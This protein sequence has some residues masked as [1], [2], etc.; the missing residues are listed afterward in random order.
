METIVN[1]RNL[2]GVAKFWE[3]YRACAEENRVRPDRSPFYVKWAKDFAGFLPEKPLETRSREHIQAFLADLG[4]RRGIAN[5]QVRQAEH[6]LRILYEIFL[7]RYARG[8]HSHGMS[9]GKQPARGPIAQTP[10]CRD[11]VIPGEVERQFPDLLDAVRT[12]VRTRHYSY[13]TETSYLDWVKRFIAFRNYADPREIDA[14]AAV[15]TYLEY[16]AVEREVAASTQNQALNALVF[17][18]GQVLQQPLGEMDQFVRARRPRRLPEVLTR[19]EIQMLLSKMTGITGLMAGLM[20][21]S[22]LRLMECVRLRV[23]DIDFAQHQILVRD[24]KGQKDRVTMLPERFATPLR[25]HLARV[26]AIYEQDSSQ[27]RADVYIWP[28]LERKYPSA[29]KE[30]IWQYVFPAKS[31]SVDPRSG[32]VRRHHINEN[33]LQKAVKEAAAQAAINKKVSCHTLRHYAE[34]GING[35][36]L[37]PIFLKPAMTFAQCRNSWGMPMWSP[38]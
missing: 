12:G 28:A 3:A 37:P 1:V 30:W 24:G 7:P 34:L 14:P 16:L 19:D 38:L 8:S 6:A 4:N 32:R 20:Y 10:V 17:F 27:G 25:E 15:R 5:W 26:K 22:G 33:L 36:P 29:Q 9:S 31:L 18:Y 11:R 35:T 2:K 13:R 21:G 23:K